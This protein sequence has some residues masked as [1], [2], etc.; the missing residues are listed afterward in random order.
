MTTRL[1]DRWTWI[2]AAHIEL[3]QLELQHSFELIQLVV[4][5]LLHC[6]YEEEF[7][8]ATNAIEI[9]SQSN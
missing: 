6:C 8:L 5:P 3:K 4:L 1:T 9:G 2:F 7:C